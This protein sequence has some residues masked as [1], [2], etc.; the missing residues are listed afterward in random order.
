MGNIDGFKRKFNQ[1]DSK[2]NSMSW[3]AR[4]PRKTGKES[5]GEKIPKNR[6]KGATFQR[7]G[8]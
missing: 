2:N 3:S 1:S 4:G 5:A 8:V 7:G 6:Q